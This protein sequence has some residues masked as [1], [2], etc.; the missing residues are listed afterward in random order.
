[1]TQVRITQVTFT[2]EGVFVGGEPLDDPTKVLVAA[3]GDPVAAL[4]MAIATAAGARPT[5][6]MPDDDVIQVIEKPLNE[7]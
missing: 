3:I 6:E 7:G 4:S 5:T 2:E 1:M